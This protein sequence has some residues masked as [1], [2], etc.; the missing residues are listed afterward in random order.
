MRVECNVAGS[1]LSVT[2]LTGLIGCVAFVD[3]AAGGFYVL[4]SDSSF[5]L[6]SKLPVGDLEQIGGVPSK[7]N[8]WRRTTGR[9]PAC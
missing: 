1:I 2:A 7:S 5:M 3:Q 9:T 8:S 6:A 4:R